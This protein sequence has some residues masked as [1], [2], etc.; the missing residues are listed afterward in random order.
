MLSAC[1]LSP[2]RFR[3]GEHI[4]YAKSVDTGPAEVPAIST[5]CADLKAQGIVSLRLGVQPHGTFQ[6]AMS[7]LVFLDT[8]WPWRWQTLDGTSGPGGREYVYDRESSYS[9]IRSKSRQTRLM[10]QDA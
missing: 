6:W 9:N 10:R 8:R 2:V 5:P 4:A 7:V 1:G 3:I